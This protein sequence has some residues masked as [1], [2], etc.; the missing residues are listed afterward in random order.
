MK[1]TEVEAGIVT[2]VWFVIIKLSQLQTM[3]DRLHGRLLTD[4]MNS[5]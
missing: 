3:K 4:G 5:G 1:T 2:Y